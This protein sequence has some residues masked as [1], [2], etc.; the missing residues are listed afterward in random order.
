MDKAVRHGDMAPGPG[1]TAYSPTAHDS[2]SE[3]RF[4]IVVWSFTE[5]Q[6]LE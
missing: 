5:K 4:A 6:K 2:G 1:L 3:P